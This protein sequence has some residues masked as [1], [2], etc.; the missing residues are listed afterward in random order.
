M[1]QSAGGGGTGHSGDAVLRRLPGRVGV[2]V[3]VLAALAFAPAAQAQPGITVRVTIDKVEAIDGFEGGGEADFYSIVSF[4]GV[5][6]AVQGPIAND[7]TADP[8]PDWIFGFG[9]DAA[10][11]R[12]PLSIEI[13]DQ[14]GGARLDDDHAD[15]DPTNGGDTFN[16][17]LEV[18]L[19]VCGSQSVF[20]AV[21]PVSGDGSIQC[22]QF[23]TSQG[24]ANN[25][26]AKITYKV[27]VFDGDVDGDFLPNS[28]EAAG[29]DADNDRT[30]DLALPALGA[31]FDRRDLFVELD[32]LVA[33]D[34]S[35][36]PRIDALT[37]V[38]R[39]FVNSPVD[40]NTGVQLHLDIGPVGSSTLVIRNVPPFNG[41]EGR[42]GNMGGGGTQIPEAGNTI[43]DWDGATGSP[44]T[45]F[46]ALKGTNFNAG[47][48]GVRRAVF[49]YAIFG[50]QT[51]SR[52]PVN[53][54]TSGW[55]EGA[56]GNDFFVTLGGRRDLNTPPDGTTDTTCW[57]DTG[58]DGFD[59]D[60]DGT[61]DE[62]PNLGVDVP[63][64]D[65]DGDCVPGTDTDGDGTPCERGDIGVDE[66]GGRSVGSRAEQA[67]TF[68]HELGHALGL[69]H[70]GN[71]A[72]TNNKPNYLS[73]MNY[74]FQMCGI[75][76]SPAGATTPIPG[77]CDYSRFVVNLDERLPPGLDECLGLGPG[78]GF[79]QNNW[80]G[81]NP[82]VFEGV[83]CPAP[84]NNNV[85]ANINNDSNPDPNN[86]GVLDPGETPLISNLPGFDD[87]RNIFFNFRGLPNFGSNTAIQPIANEP[88]PRTIEIAQGHLSD[89][90]APEIN[91]TVS[92][93]ATALPGESLNYTIRTANDGDGPAFGVGLA[94]TRPDG[95][96]SSFNLGDLI[97][98]SDDSRTIGYSVPAN[99]CPQT[100]T[101]GASATFTDFV[102]QLH[103]VSGSKDTRVL[104]IT[105]PTIQLSVSPTSLWPPNHKL[106]NIRATVSAADECDPNPTVRLVSVTSSEP[107]N[108]PGDGNTTGDIAG[109]AL[110]TDDRSFQ[111]RAERAGSGPGRIYTVVYEVRDASGNATRATATIRVP[112]DK[113]G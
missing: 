32:C 28:W 93:P 65:D 61:R 5:P 56:P 25:N 44:G 4:D 6:G 83:S 20:P 87:W 15:I 76:A 85:Q 75:Q 66:D 111:V 29:I 62:D 21:N 82:P 90:L 74:A 27:E 14:D 89:L 51:N 109:A 77:G 26:K 106:A 41:T 47:I 81:D 37:D 72:V 59:D 30:V 110:G 33:A 17:E 100:L 3:A 13:R 112:K 97:V 102:R 24:T 40:A 105:P 79:G 99:A 88:D 50:H 63:A 38:V 45:S 101:V 23:V 67:G 16:L 36:C 46:Y 49:R 2:F 34:H 12:V 108:G 22:G 57:G 91:V 53:D 43:I 8:N 69:Q 78:L 9:T 98:G 55:A 92:G 11:G 42:I 39:A 18:N 107:D 86:N 103:F 31:R 73:V 7:N 68:M 113:P 48:Q 80:D 19:A 84:N 35:H 94:V 52:V 10:R 104:D 70:G 64:V 96:M 95:S 71:D 60:G 54:C 1:R 58:T